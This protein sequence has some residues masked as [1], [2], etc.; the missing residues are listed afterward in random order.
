M[1]VGDGLR[2]SPDAPRPPMAQ[3][4]DFDCFP[5]TPRCRPKYTHGTTD[6]VFA[7][8]N[9]LRLRYATN[10][11]HDE[12]A[13]PVLGFAGI[14]DGDDVGVPQVRH[15]IGFAFESFPRSGGWLATLA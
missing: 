4:G 15:E 14:K 8:R 12:V 10:M 13:A 11:V 3:C 1:P 2:G 6:I 5:V 9:I 7:F